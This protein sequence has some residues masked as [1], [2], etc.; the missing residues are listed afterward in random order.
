MR[1]SHVNSVQKHGRPGVIQ[2]SELVFFIVKAVEADWNTILVS[3]LNAIDVDKALVLLLFALEHL[4]CK[5]VQVAQL[6]LCVKLIVR[7]GFIELRR[8]VDYYLANFV[9]KD[10]LLG[11]KESHGRSYLQA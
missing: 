4:L 2:T 11:R 8:L 10:A 3:L 5:S 6:E 9:D 7:A 1:T